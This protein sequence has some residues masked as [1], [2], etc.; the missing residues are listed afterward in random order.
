MTTMNNAVNILKKTLLAVSLL[1]FGLTV[2]HAALPTLTPYSFGRIQDNITLGSNSGTTDSLNTNAGLLYV[3]DHA[4]NNSV[5]HVGYK[6]DLTGTDWSFITPETRFTLSITVNGID[7][8]GWNPIALYHVPTHA[9]EN[10]T[11]SIIL[12][13]TLVSTYDTT[14]IKVEDV[15]VFDVTDYIL[16]DINNGLNFSTFRVSQASLFNNGNGVRDALILNSQPI[17]SAIPEPSHF[18]LLLAGL[19][20]LGLLYQR[21]KK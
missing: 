21:R 8:A 9:N 10:V 12:G 3:G 5:Y 13:G 16:D 4:N 2:T 1:G 6:F 7:E 19:L 11:V 18:G 15:M 14:G 20:T 17:I